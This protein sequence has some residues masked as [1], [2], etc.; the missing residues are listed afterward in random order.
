MHRHGARRNARIRTTYRVWVTAGLLL[1]LSSAV[2]ADPIFSAK[3]NQEVQE[4]SSGTPQFAVSQ[5]QPIT[6]FRVGYQSSFFPTTGGI[7][8][9]YYFQLPA[10]PSGQA[11]STATFSVSEL[12]E[13]TTGTTPTFNVD[14]YAAGYDTSGNPFATDDPSPSYG[15]GGVASTSTAQTYFY[16]GANQTG[17]TGANGLAITK[18]TDDMFT[19]T[20]WTA[21]KTAGSNVAKT[22]DASVGSALANYIQGIYNN[23]S[24]DGGGGYLILRLTPDDANSL[25]SGTQRY[26]FPYAVGTAPPG[27]SD[28]DYSSYGTITEAQVNLTFA[29]VPEPAS[30]G[31]IG[32]AAVGL[33]ARRKR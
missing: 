7:A 6:G 5:A 18:L 33:L 1:A 22:T 9:L 21:A 29:A 3:Y 16:T 25:S 28:P 10:L 13:G 12:H 15:S 23:P 14:L 20:D 19:P 8:T 26:Q 31:L 32:F 27:K 17:A 24:F 4:R 2:Q 11:V 30:I